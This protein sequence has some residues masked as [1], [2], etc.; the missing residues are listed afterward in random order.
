MLYNRQEVE[1]YQK[2]AVYTESYLK[3][4]P[5]EIAAYQPRTDHEVAD[6]P[7]PVVHITMKS[8]EVICAYMTI[9]KFET[10]LNSHNN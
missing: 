6:E 4:N 5:F 8:G 7:V 2:E 3:L 1:V 9:S 10:L